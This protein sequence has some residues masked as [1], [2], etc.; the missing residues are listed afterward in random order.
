VVEILFAPEPACIIGIS[1]WR[2]AGLVNMFQ[3]TDRRQI[4]PQESA[5]R[6]QVDSSE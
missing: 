1:G 4:K 5:W 2:E 6:D 3:N